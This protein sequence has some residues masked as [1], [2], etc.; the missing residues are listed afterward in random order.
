VDLK[1]LASVEGFEVGGADDLAKQLQAK[2]NAQ[3]KQIKQLKATESAALNVMLGKKNTWKSKEQ[4]QAAKKASKEEKIKRLT[5][6]EQAAMEKIKGQ[7]AT[8]ETK[9]KELAAKKALAQAKAGGLVKKAGELVQKNDAK[10]MKIKK[11]EATE[12]AALRKMTGQKA[13]WKTKEEEQAAKKALAE[14]KSGGLVKK[15]GELV[16]KNEAMEKQN[17]NQVRACDEKMAKM[18]MS[19]NEWK[20]L[21]EEKQYKAAMQ[22]GGVMKYAME[23]LSKNKACTKE[24]A[25]AAPTPKDM[26]MVQLKITAH[27]LATKKVKLSAQVT[28]C[29]KARRQYEGPL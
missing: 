18:H 13:S 28:Q 5:A 29:E 4:E 21:K 3:E 22:S 7:K 19:K 6:A 9:E 15:A 10:E 17:K 1:N 12:E 24:L 11:Q 23:L 20:M 26:S 27:E 8:L 2:L 14:A 25:A 16:L